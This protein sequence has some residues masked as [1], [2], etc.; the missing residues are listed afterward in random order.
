VKSLQ[1]AR[2]VASKV[3]HD[4]LLHRFATFNFTT[5]IIGY[6]AVGVL[7]SQGVAGSYWANT[8]V[9]KGMAPAG[10][11]ADTKALTGR[12]RPTSAQ[13][14]KWVAYWLPSA[15]M[16]MVVLGIVVAFG[17][18]G[19]KARAATGLVLFPL[20]YVVKRFV[21]FTRQTWASRFL[22]QGKLQ[23]QQAYHKFVMTRMV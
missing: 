9:S 23:V 2:T 15:L 22:D 3:L 11:L 1:F 14:A 17:I 13:V 7:M 21:V 19:L 5:C 20:G 16:G 6:V 10:L 12:F 8:F 18:E 4:R